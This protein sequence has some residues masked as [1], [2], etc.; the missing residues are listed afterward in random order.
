MAQKTYRKMHKACFKKFPVCK[1]CGSIWKFEDCIEGSGLHQRPK[2]CSYTNPFRRD[3]QKCNGILLKTVELA[4][5]RTI[6]YPLMTYCYIDIRTSLQNLVLDPRFTRQC[7]HWKSLNFSDSL[8][9]DAYDGRVWKRFRQFDGVPFLDDD[10]AYAVMINMDW[11]Q[12][13][14]HLTYSVGVIYLSIFNLPRGS[15]YKLQNICLVGIIPG[16]REPELTVNQY[17][18]SMVEDL[19]HFWDGVQLEVCVNSHIERKIVRCAIICCSCDLP[20]GRKLCGFMGHSAHLGCSKCTKRFPSAES[21]LDYSG[22]Q[23]ENWIPRS[24][25]SHRQNV[26]KLRQ[27]KSKSALRK[28]ESELGCR[29]SVLLE[30]PYFDVPTMLVIDPMHCLFLGL[31]KVFLK[32]V[33]IGR[34]ILSN[35]VLATIEQRVN[36]MKVPSDIG[37]IPH[38]IE[39]AFYNFSADQYKNWV[40]H[41]SIICLHGMLS[42]EH[43]ECWRHF[44]LACRY[45]CQPVLK[46][47]DVRIADALLLK[48]C[49]RTELLFGK[50]V[51]TPNM[52]M[53]CHLRECILD[54]GPLNHFWLF[55]FERFNGI[56]GQLPNNNKSIETQMMK[57]FIAD[58]EIFRVPIPTEFKDDFENL[59]SFQRSPVGTLGMDVIQS[60]TDC[61]DR[62]IRIPHNST[63]YVFDAAEMD[64]LTHFFA[65]FYP[66]STC[67]IASTCRKYLVIGIGGKV[68]GSYKSRSS[69]SSIILAM[70]EAE[71]RPARIN[72]FAKVS[73]LVDG[74]HCNHIVVCLSWYKHH[75]QSDKCGKPVTIWEHDLFDL[76]SFLLVEDITCRTVSLVDKLNEMVGN[77]LFVSPYY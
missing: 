17:L 67:Q 5:G 15:R 45:I 22:F 41:Y 13:Y 16:P 50:D 33:L 46:P 36:A 73:I 39:H 75:A 10:Y 12:P 7:A 61:A 43:L 65:R 74:E 71:T 34:G 3:R 52:H 40:M 32:K 54:Y 55:A 66:S 48:F 62:E 53:S 2:L 24:D 26:R 28:M 23:R 8:L 11:F 18:N 30:L 56:L 42:S 20:A 19:L 14:K 47:E 76:Y 1:H 63:R 64:K 25:T 21:G 49:S 60:S 69:N 6:F 29:Y 68:Y 70:L 35:T 77:V 38:K 31:A 51:I 37:R 59:V 27:C 4:S 58:T 9:R 72:Y 57:R 44:V